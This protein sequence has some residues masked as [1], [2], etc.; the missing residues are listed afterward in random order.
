M[1]NFQNRRSKSTPTSRSTAPAVGTGCCFTCP[2]PITCGSGWQIA[3]LALLAV[4][5]GKI[6]RLALLAVASGRSPARHRP[7]IK[8]QSVARSRPALRP[9][10]RCLRS[11]DTPLPC[12]L[13]SQRV[14]YAVREELTGGGATRCIAARPT[15][16]ETT[17]S[18]GRYCGGRD[19]P[20]IY[21]VV[22][23]NPSELSALS[24][25]KSV[26][27][28]EGGRRGRARGQER[29]V[30]AGTRRRGGG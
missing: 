30:P 10:H 2:R 29:R 4:A 8:K 19:E 22:G 5:G 16:R 14:A 18:S 9:R 6:A 12:A 25:P 1:H 27:L 28:G 15:G 3:R 11:R 20:N 13:C 21:R 24:H 7:P 23:R 17:W 26:Y